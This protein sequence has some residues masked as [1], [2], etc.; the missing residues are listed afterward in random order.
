MPVALKEP[1]LTL[2]IDSLSK[3]TSIND[4]DI[5]VMWLAIT[6]SKHCLQNG[7]RLENLS[8]R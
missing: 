4:D 6:K 5:S 7:P 3:L 2:A 1:V 8:W